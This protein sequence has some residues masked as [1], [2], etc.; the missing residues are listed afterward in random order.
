MILQRETPSAVRSAPFSRET[1]PSDGASPTKK[2]HDALKTLPPPRSSL[3]A[4]T[5]RCP[6]AAIS[7][8]LSV[9]T[10]PVAYRTFAVR[11]RWFRDTTSAL[12][13]MPSSGQYSCFARFAGA[14]RGRGRR[15]EFAFHGRSVSGRLTK[16]SKGKGTNARNRKKKSLK[17]AWGSTDREPPRGGL[18]RRFF[19]FQKDRPN[20]GARKASFLAGEP[21]L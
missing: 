9:S 20:R 12:Y 5:L 18:N 16:Q 4:Q 14:R 2:R 21:P 8:T 17:A 11:A 15:G 7:S 13:H 19:P 10:S 3:Y 1:R 6:S